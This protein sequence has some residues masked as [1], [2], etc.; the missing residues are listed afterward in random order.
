MYTQGDSIAIAA[1]TGAALLT[2]DNASATFNIGLGADDLLPATNALIDPNVRVSHGNMSMAAWKDAYLLER[3]MWAANSQITL[4]G[5]SDA[6]VS[7]AW[8]EYKQLLEATT[9][10]GLSRFSGLVRESEN[11]DADYQSAI[12]ASEDIFEIVE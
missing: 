6:I 8:N 4:A 9:S 2:L 10:G 11:T 1:T 3:D 12:V 5:S 7:M